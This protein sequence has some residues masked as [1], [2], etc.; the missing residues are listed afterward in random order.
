[1]IENDWCARP[2][3]SWPNEEYEHELRWYTTL[4]L[5]SPMGHGIIEHARHGQITVITPFTLAGA[6]APVTIAGA[7]AQQNAEFLAGLSLA[8]CARPGAPIIYGGFTSNVDMKTGAPAFGTPEYVKAV[9]AGG[10]LTRRYGVP[11]R[12]SGV[13]AANIPDAQAAWETQMSLWGTMTG[14][15]DM[16]MHAA[17]WM[18]GGLAASFEKMVI[19]AD[20]IQMLQSYMQPI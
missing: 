10:Q 2:S 11:Y 6:M 13:C 9:Q 7:L 20:M 8:Q 18:E 15:A 1:M 17:G 14:G 4:K 12:S 3:E 5:D 16:V 19:D